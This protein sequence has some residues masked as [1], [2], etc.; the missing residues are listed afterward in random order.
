MKLHRVLVAAVID[1]VERILAEGQYAD[2]VIEKLLRS[3]PQWG[4]RDRAFL[5]EIVTTLSVI[6]DCINFAAEI[7]KTTGAFSKVIWY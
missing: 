6:G 5:A 1:A 2:R 7:K 3:N 4:A